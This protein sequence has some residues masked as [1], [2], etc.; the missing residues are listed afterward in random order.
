LSGELDGEFSANELAMGI[1]G[2]LNTCVMVPLLAP[3]CPLDRQAARQIVRFFLE[4]AARRQAV[5][6]VH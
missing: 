2:Q 4:G 1:Y 6:P 5:P 3:E